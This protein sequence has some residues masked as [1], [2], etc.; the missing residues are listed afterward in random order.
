[1]T[2]EIPSIEFGRVEHGWAHVTVRHGSHLFEA[3]V[4]DLTDGLAEFITAIE[5]VATSRL[6]G[7]ECRWEVEPGFYAVVLRSRNEH[8]YVELSIGYDADNYRVPEFLR[9]PEP[10]FRVIF[11]VRVLVRDAI[12]AY[13]SLLERHGADGYL[14]RWNYAFPQVQVDA[15][16]AWLE[17]DATRWDTPNGL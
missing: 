10:G 6:S 12:T 8:P 11:D 3:V 1:M 2:E 5:L 16:S 7:A 15:L 13:R 14:E 9:E 4:S 17:W